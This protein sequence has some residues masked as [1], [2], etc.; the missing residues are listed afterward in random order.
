[1]GQ[2]YRFAV[3]DGLEKYEQPSDAVLARILRSFP[4]YD[5]YEIVKSDYGCVIVYVW[6]GERLYMGVWE[7]GVIQKYRLDLSN[8]CSEEMGLDKSG[9]DGVR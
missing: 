8:I 7:N 9:G 5:S 1:M 2:K 6:V 4:Y 3:Q